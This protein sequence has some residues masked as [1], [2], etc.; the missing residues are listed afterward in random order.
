VRVV[1]VVRKLRELKREGVRMVWMSLFFRSFRHA[2]R[3]W[4]EKIV[5]QAT[6]RGWIGYDTIGEGMG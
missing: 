5:K 6:G 4:M 1:R 2:K 3:T